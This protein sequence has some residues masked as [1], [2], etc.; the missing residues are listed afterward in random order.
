VRAESAQG[1]ALLVRLR[2]EFGGFTGQLT[3]PGG[4]V[5]FE[6][7]TTPRS[8]W[9]EL[10]SSWCTMLPAGSP[11]A[12]IGMARC[13]LRPRQRRVPLSTGWIYR[14]QPGGQPAQWWRCRG[15]WS[16]SLSWRASQA[17]PDA[18][19]SRRRLDSRILDSRPLL[20]VLLNIAADQASSSKS[21]ASIPIPNRCG[22]F[23]G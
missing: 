10:I 7:P 12:A 6:T 4:Q 23:A 18:D 17:A 5:V 19:R 16:S 2:L 8:T 21:S 9:P 15:A 14:V 3:Q 13:G 11:I 20:L 1:A 22:P